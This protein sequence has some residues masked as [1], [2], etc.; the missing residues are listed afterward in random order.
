MGYTAAPDSARLLLVCCDSTG[1][2]D[3]SQVVDL[4]HDLSSIMRLVAQACRDLT[5]C[6]AGKS[7]WKVSQIQSTSSGRC[8]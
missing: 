4:G 1:D 8:R 7:S 3:L 5:V 6:G 2:V